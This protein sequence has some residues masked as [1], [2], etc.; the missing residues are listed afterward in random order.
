MFSRSLPR[1][2][3]VCALLFVAAALLAGAFAGVPKGPP[4]NAGSAGNVTVYRDGFGVPHIYGDT[5]EAA[6]YAL[7]YVQAQDHLEQMRRNYLTAAGRLA[8]FGLGSAANDNNVYRLHVPQT[9]QASYQA[10]VPEHRSRVDAFVAG[11]NRYIFE[12][13][14]TLADWIS[15]VQPYEVLAWMHYLAMAEQNSIAISDMNAGGAGSGTQVEDASNM[16]AVSPSMSTLGVT[17]LNGDPHLPWT[18]FTRQWYEAHLNY[19]G[20]NVA[21]SLL[22][23]FP[24][25]VM[26]ANDNVAWTM[27]NNG[28]DTADIY[29]ETVNPE[30]ALQYLRDGAWVNVQAE[31]VTIKEKVGEDIVEQTFTNY[32]SVHGP[33]IGIGSGV[34]YSAAMS[35]F[36]NVISRFVLF[37]VNE[38][39]SI[40]T[41]LDPTQVPDMHKWNIIAADRAGNI[42]YI[43][44]A[45]MADKPESIAWSQPVDGSTS[46]NDW[47]PF[48]TAGELP[49]TTN[50][51]W[52][53][54]QN[55]NNSAWTT[56]PDLNPD[57]FPSYIGG[58]RSGSLGDRGTRAVEVLES[59]SQ[60][61]IQ[62]MITMGFDSLSVRAR[63]FIPVA[64]DVWAEVGPGT[65]DPSGDL[66][67]AMDLFVGWDFVQDRESPETALGR[68]FIDSFYDSNPGFS[69]S[70][71][72][73]AD[74][75]S[76]ADKDK[77]VAALQTSTDFMLADIGQLD[78]LW[79]DVHKIQRGSQAFRVGGGG[80]GL[81]ALHMAN[82]DQ[83]DSGVWWAESGSSYIFS[84]AFT[85]PITFY[86]IRPLGESEDP[87]S[88]HYADQTQLYVNEQVKQVWMTLADVQANA[89]SSFSLSYDGPAHNT[90]GDGCTDGQE[91]G[92]DELLGGQRDPTNPWDFYDVPGPGGAPPDGE[93]DLFN[94]ILGVILHYS[95]DGGPPYDV[96]FDRGP[97]TGPNAWNMTAPDGS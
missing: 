80:R 97:S 22:F 92:A 81:P 19:P 49:Q 16:W 15:Y 45:R 62:D 94:D 46:A 21:G 41:I 10:L 66:Q 54:L 30:N 61:S 52:G 25:I 58:G 11:I 20:T 31:T 28:A 75:W 23:G 85:D 4:A 77:L 27:T 35:S 34:Y 70:S 68:L 96:Q 83:F 48:L 18:G 74:Q 43:W 44:S 1:P 55:A 42:S 78:P 86:S 71:V 9:A 50:P 63:L 14:A 93:I 53:Y 39:T 64:L 72:P 76:Q 65:P 88:P 37:D 2:A 59:R 8:E 51:S 38:A 79:G 13:A 32:Y 73:P 90:D 26:G 91:L 6:A 67:A 3:I 40:A 87:S 47:G 29:A 24:A 17:M 95:L 7:G 84:V 5:A 12:E 56:A 36:D 69:A 33:L 89:E 57:D 82:V 60:H